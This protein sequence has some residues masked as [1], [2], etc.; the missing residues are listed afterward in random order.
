MTGD[1]GIER[2]T[3]PG[4]RARDDDAGR[5]V[6]EHERCV[7]ARVADPAGRHPV[8]IGAAQAHGAHPHDRFARLRLTVR[9]LVQAQVAGSVQPER[10]HSGCP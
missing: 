3:L 4:A 2:D 5:L 7:E 8:A 10:F 1:G 9:L 6:P